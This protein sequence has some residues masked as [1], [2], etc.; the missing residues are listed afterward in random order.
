MDKTMEKLKDVVT[1]EIDKLVK[2]GTLSPN[3]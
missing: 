2:Q 3:E 1:E